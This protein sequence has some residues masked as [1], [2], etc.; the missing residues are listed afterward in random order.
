M[1]GA[2][3]A[4]WVALG[5]L[6]CLGIVLGAARLYLCSAAA[7]GL[8]AGR[9]ETAYG[10]RVAVSS[11]AIDFGGSRFQNIQF[12]ETD[13]ESSDLPWITI[14]EMKSSAGV[15]DALRGKTPAVWML[16]GVDV[17]LRFDATGHLLTHWP[18]PKTAAAATSAFKIEGG[19][20]TLKQEGRPDLVVTDFTGELHPEGE[21]LA[22]TGTC[23]EARWG[24]WA[25]LGSWDRASGDAS[26]RLL[27]PQASFTQKQLETL[28][29]VSPRVWNQVKIDGDAGVDLTVRWDAVAGRV[30]YRAALDVEKAKLH[31]TSIDLKTTDTGGKVVVED[32]LVT[33]TDLHGQSADGDI[34]TSGDLD[35]RH[36]PEALKFKVAVERVRVERLPRRWFP[37]RFLAFRPKGRLSGTADL[38]VKISEGGAYT[39]GE[40]HGVIREAFLMNAPA[41]KPISLRLHAEGKT[42]TLTPDKGGT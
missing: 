15:V 1:K 28:P 35:F 40:G 42:F 27:T 17:T 12:F 36:A 30:R 11:A 9:I 38:Q 2:R 3:R 13:P 29:F 8:V 6:L 39:T 21:R 22:L 24:Q 31:I 10:G 26:L 5:L 18:K 25:A 14:A 32:G 41:L 19:Q 33:L 20:V 4:L 16:N 34:Q 23:Q 37:E 7:A